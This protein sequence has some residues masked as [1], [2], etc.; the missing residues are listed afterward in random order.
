M[1]E[2]KERKNRRTRGKLIC[3][4]TAFIF[5][6]LPFVLFVLMLND[7]NDQKKLDKKRLDENDDGSS[8]LAFPLVQ[9]VC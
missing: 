6:Q 1:K 3:L 5:T 2:K 8:Y 9:I 4:D 7:D